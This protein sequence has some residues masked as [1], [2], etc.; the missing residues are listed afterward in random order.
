MYILL[1]VSRYMKKLSA[2]L[3]CTGLLGSTLVADAAEK[4]DFYELLEAIYSQW[5]EEVVYEV[6]QERL[7]E[8]YND[9]LVLNEASREDLRL[10]CILTE[11][12][13]DQLFKHVAKNG[14]LISIYELQAI[15]GFDLATIQLLVPFVSIEEV[16]DYY[17]S[18]SGAYKG[19]EA[20]NSYGLMRYER[21][22]ETDHDYQHNRKQNKVPYVGSPNKLFTRLSAK[23]PSGWELGLAAR[24]GAGEAF[25]WDPET[26]RYGLAPW[27]FYWLVKNYKRVKALV[28]G[29]YALGYG[30]GLVLN[31]G[32]SVNKSSETIKVIRTNNLGI[33]P[34]TSVATTAFRGIAATWQWQPIALTTYYS[35]VDLDGKVAHNASGEKHVRSVSRQGYYRTQS[36]IAKKG[37]VNEHVIGSTLVYKDPARGAELGINVLYSY[38]SLPIC[39]DTQRGN[40]LRFR[41]QDH[42][43][44]SLF[45]RY[46][47]QNLHFFGEGALSKNGG[48]AA[49][50]GAVASLSRYADATVL[51]RHYGQNFHSPYGKAF[52]ENSSSNSNE[53]GIYLGASI[54]PWHRL[55]LDAYYDYF[56]FPWCFGKPCSGYSWLAKATYQL[57]KTSL[58]SLQRKITTKPRRV[59]KTKQ[60]SVHISQRYKLRWQHTLNKA[61]HIK[62]EMQCGCHQQPGASTWNYA[63][64]QD[65]AYKIRGLQ[66]K[67]HVVWFNAQDTNNKLYFYEP[68]VL[69]TGFNFRSYQGRGMRY[70]L[71]VCYQPTATFRL[72]LKYGLTYRTDQNEVRDSQ[73]TTQSNA[74]NDVT[75]Q[76]IFKF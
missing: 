4:K 17:R 25:T 74:K 12:Q 75:L 72:E 61:I 67:G 45:Y 54:K 36:E 1:F 16:S 42:A 57:T 40:P 64:A 53:R 18:R 24:K 69:Y 20:R 49:M 65:V 28:V 48:Q 11:D 55:H 41:G 51:W 38:Y 9:P 13:L 2:G 8:Y 43:N 3:I 39:P 68:N 10:L 6:L 46:L 23:H 21:T 29:D 7:W 26:Q 15:A 19:L 50:A 59:A 34:H 31:A 63:V 30:Q 37:Q 70:C 33:R 62:S 56:Y 60:T 5:E 52:R 22:L 76:A 44:G 47:W 32:F 58:I 66:L 73:K 71:L 27:R 35:N 14:P